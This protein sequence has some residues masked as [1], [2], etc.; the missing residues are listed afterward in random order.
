MRILFH[1]HAPG[2]RNDL[3]EQF[4]EFKIECKIVRCSPVSSPKGVQTH[5]VL[6][7]VCGTRCCF[8][9]S[10]VRLSEVI[11]FHEGWEDRSCCC[12][13]PRW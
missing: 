1:S 2:S 12:E 3:A 6:I 10:F 4:P 13:N 9:G 8:F 11:C 5:L 7:K